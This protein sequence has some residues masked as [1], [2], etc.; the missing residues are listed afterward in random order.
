[1]IRRPPRSTLFPYTTLFRSRGALVP[2]RSRRGSRGSDTSGRRSRPS[3]AARGALLPIPRLRGKDPADP[4]ARVVRV[5][6]IAGD[7]VD[8]HVIDRLPRRLTHVD[9]EVVAVGGELTLE[10]R[11][12]RIDEPPHRGLLSGG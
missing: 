9:A 12:Y 11:P 1:M 5:A 10:P 7:Q 2:L 3:V 4:A 8:V 6:R